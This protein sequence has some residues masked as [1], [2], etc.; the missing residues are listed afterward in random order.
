MAKVEYPKFIYKAGEA[1]KIVRSKEEHDAHDGWQEEPAAEVEVAPESALEPVAAKPAAKPK[2]E[3][4]QKAA[5]PA[6]EK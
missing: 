5:K 2:K 1:A 4:K 3:K 6:E